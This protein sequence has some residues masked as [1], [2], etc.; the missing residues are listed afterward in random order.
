MGDIITA[1]VGVCTPIMHF[2]MAFHGEVG[3]TK[4]EYGL[5][6]DMETLSRSPSSVIILRRPL[7]TRRGSRA[8]KYGGI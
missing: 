3:G 8:K 6:R 2:F 5:C 4:E 7:G 1:P